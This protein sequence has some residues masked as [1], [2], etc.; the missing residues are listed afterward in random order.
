MT[1]EPQVA[2]TA[3]ESTSGPGT[4]RTFQGPPRGLRT[5]VMR[6]SYIALLV[7]QIPAE[8]SH[9]HW[10]VFIV[11]VAANGLLLWTERPWLIGTGGSGRGWAPDL[12]WPRGWRRPLIGRQEPRRRRERR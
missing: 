3:T 9:I 7:A 2:M 8:E 10:L 5:T 6:L 11:S 1:P 12:G 4:R